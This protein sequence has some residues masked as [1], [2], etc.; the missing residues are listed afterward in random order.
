VGADDVVAAASRGE[1]W[2]LTELFRAYQ[3]GLVRFLRGQERAAADDLAGEVW[4]AVAHRLGEFVGDERAFRCWLFTIARNRLADYRR[5]AARRRTAPLP[6]DEIEPYLESGRSADPADVVVGDMAAQE[7]IDQLVGEL[8]P[9]QAE[10][11][12]LRVV[13][14]FDVAEVASITG[15]SAGA[16]R[17]LQCRALK[18]LA[19][20]PAARVVTR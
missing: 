9:A 7:A 1:R 5:R 10:V 15:R 16:V 8:P 13:G 19:S 6:A 12:L 2:A 14:G 18:R 4:M 17:V 11:V 20:T 3:P